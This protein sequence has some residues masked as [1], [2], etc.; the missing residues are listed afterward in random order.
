M[1]RGVWRSL[2]ARFVRDEEVVGSN[3]A[4]PTCK[5]AVQSLDRRFDR[6]SFC[7]AVRRK[8]P[9]SANRKSPFLVDV[10][11]GVIAGQGGIAV[12]AGRRARQCAAPQLLYTPQLL[13]PARA[14]GAAVVGGSSS[15]S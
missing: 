1:R 10:S 11:R 4:T 5:G 7:I 13:H 2:V 14:L 3:P 6:G 12:T 8:L 9:R 15:S